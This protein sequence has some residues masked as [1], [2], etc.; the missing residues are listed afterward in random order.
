MKPHWLR[1]VTVATILPFRHDSSIDWPGF[2]RLLEYCTTPPDVTSVFVNGHAGESSALTREER[3]EVIR[4]VRKHLAPAQCLVAGLV[5]DSTAGCIEQALQARDAGADVLTV[6]PL[7]FPGLADAPRLQAQVAHVRA[8]GEATGLP[9]AI[10]QY[11]STSPATYST[12][13]LV[14]LAKLPWVVGIKEGSDSMTLYEDNLRA[15]KAANPDLLMMPSNFDWFLPQLA[16]G[17]DGLLSGLASL[18]PGALSQLWRASEAKD[19]DAMRRASDALY[20]LVRAVYAAPRDYMYARM[21][22]PL[23]ELGVIE[24]EVS[25]TRGTVAS[26]TER[27]ALR[28]GFAAVREMH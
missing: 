17:A 18:A 26:P 15:T 1:R 7:E 20:P 13:A 4:F 16:V 10:F 19:L 11:P 27:E 2:R 14:E 12:A 8:I 25:R 23:C 21:K 22:I 3:G 28:R 6:F 9:L 24:T 5:A